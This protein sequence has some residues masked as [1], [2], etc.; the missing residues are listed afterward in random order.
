MTSPITHCQKQPI[1]IKA[2][3]VEQIIDGHYIMFVNSIRKLHTRCPAEDIITLT[4]GYIYSQPPGYT[5]ETEFHKYSNEGI[6][7]VHKPLLL[8]GLVIPE[9]PQEEKSIPLVLHDIPLTNLRAALPSANIQP[10]REIHILFP[11]AFYKLSKR[12]RYIQNSWITQ[13]ARATPARLP[14]D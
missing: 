8:P 13:A 11:F 6:N 9:A 7:E 3:S 4:E 10:L 14:E 2:D 12:R 1:I 5:F